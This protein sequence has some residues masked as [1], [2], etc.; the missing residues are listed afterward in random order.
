MSFTLQ[1]MELSSKHTFKEQHGPREQAVKALQCTLSM[2]CKPM[3]PQ[4]GPPVGK[5]QAS[6]PCVL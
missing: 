4:L 3:Q 6:C 1:A 2:A 5:Q